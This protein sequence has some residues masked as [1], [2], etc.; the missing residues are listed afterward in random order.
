MLDGLEITQFTY[1][2]QCGGIDLDLVPAEMTYGLE[3]LA[4]FLQFRDSVYDIEW[5][6]GFTY[7][8]VRFQDELQYSVYNFEMADVPTLWKL[9]ELHEGEAA[10]LLELYTRSRPKRRASRC[11]P[12]Y[13]QVLKCSNIF[14]T[15]DARGA[16]SVTERVGVIARVRK[17][18]VG[19]AQAGWISRRPSQ[20]AG[21]GGMSVPFLLEIGT[22]EIPDWMIPGALESLREP[23]C[24]RLF[25]RWAKFTA[26]CHAAP[27]GAARG[28]RARARRRIRRSWSQGPAKTAPPKA[29]E[30]FAQQARRA[31]RGSAGAVDRQGRILHFPA[32][33]IEG[34]AT[35]DILAEALP[36]VIPKIYFPKT[37]YWTGKNGPRFIRPIRW[38]VALLGDEVVPFEIAG[39]KSGKMT[40][41]HRRLGRGEISGDMRRTTNSSFARTS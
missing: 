19:A 26:G 1:F 22:E 38:I 34:R 2:Q 18:A 16:I 39:V 37:M 20:R 21:G 8:D 27:A 32:S 12:T 33:K 4:A 14:N 31:R 7:R 15:L 29:V 30:G 24:R 17:L 10:R 36:G 25:R 9:F 3:R 28:G 6:P 13:D 41:G 40:C 5:T 23:G 11:C 35:K